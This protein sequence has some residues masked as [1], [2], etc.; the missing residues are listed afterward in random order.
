MNL[1]II[2]FLASGEQQH[3]VGSTYRISKQHF[4]VI[5]EIVCDGICTALQGEFAKWTTQNMLK[6]ARGFQDKCDFPN[7]VG[8]V[9]G[10]HVAMKAPPNSEGQFKNYKVRLFIIRN[11]I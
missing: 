2:R 9:S 1:F 4:G 3:H 10:K 11:I 7:C 8:A 5:V 6:W